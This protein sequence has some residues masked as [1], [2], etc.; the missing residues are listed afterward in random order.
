MAEEHSTSEARCSFVVLF[1]IGMPM[2]TNLPM[3]SLFL[4]DEESI[5]RGTIEVVP[6]FVCGSWWIKKNGDVFGG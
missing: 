4:E 2:G 1:P 3:V 6:R 5:E